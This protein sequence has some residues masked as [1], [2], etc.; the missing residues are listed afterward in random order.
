M[1]YYGTTNTQYKY[2]EDVTFTNQPLLY[3]VMHVYRKANLVADGL[4]DFGLSLLPSLYN[5]FTKL[6]GII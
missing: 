1:V 6:I 3:Q 5:E 2:N 4:A